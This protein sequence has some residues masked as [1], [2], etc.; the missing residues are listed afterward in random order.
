[1]QERSIRALDLNL[2]VTLHALLE[3]RSVTRAAERVGVS[4]P[5]A[6]AALGRL[7]RY[8]GDELLKRS[9]GKSR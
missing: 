9:G 2:L 3:E 5:A 4:Q 1:M 8:F 7:R 6:S